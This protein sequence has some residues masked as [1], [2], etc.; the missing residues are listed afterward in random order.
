M[1][2]IVIDLGL[3][4]CRAWAVRVLRF[5]VQ[6]L[7]PAQIMGPHQ[8]PNLVQP[9]FL[10]LVTCVNWSF[11]CTPYSKPYKKGQDPWKE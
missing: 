2:F 3:F 4:R 6:R 1:G 8:N 9:V 11:A 10:K 5:R 7:K